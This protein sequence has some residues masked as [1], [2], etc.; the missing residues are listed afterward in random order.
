MTMMK[1]EELTSNALREIG[2]DCSSTTIKHAVKTAMKRLPARLNKHSRADVRSH[3]VACEAVK[4]IIK[5][6]P[7]YPS[8][9]DRYD[10]WELKHAY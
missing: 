9:Y 6:Y 7:C 10:R 3:E 5:E 2:P 8:Y 4:I 1:I